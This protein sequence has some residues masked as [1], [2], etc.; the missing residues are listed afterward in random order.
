MAAVSKK[1][2]SVPPTPRTV[3]SEEY[4]EDEYDQKSSSLSRG[5]SAQQLP[6]LARSC[7]APPPSPAS[8]LE[9]SPVD[10]LI[11][12]ELQLVRKELRGQDPNKIPLKYQFFFQ[13]QAINNGTPLLVNVNEIAQGTTILLRAG[14]AIQN[15]HLTVRWRSYYDPTSVST[16]F[17]PPDDLKPNFVRFIVFRYYIPEDA[18]KSQITLADMV[19]TQAALPTDSTSIYWTVTA[20][21]DTALTMVRN[22]NTRRIAKVLHDSTHP[23]GG[24]T[25]ASGSFLAASTASVVQVGQAFHEEH[26]HLDFESAFAGT[27]AVDIL[28]NGIYCCWFTDQV[29]G[30]RNQCVVQSTIQMSFEDIGGFA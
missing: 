14:N 6:V 30:K 26:V 3:L 21:N 2:V 19:S 24:M 15:R 9:K 18:V 25:N 12:T 27:A 13:S 5:G 22:P 7:N 16:A 10:S 17:D 23:V 8:S 28:T 11:Q 4:F 29:A 20:T 1:S